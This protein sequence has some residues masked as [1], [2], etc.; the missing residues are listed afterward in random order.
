M[1]ANRWRMSAFLPRAAPLDVGGLGTDTRESFLHGLGDELRSAALEGRGHIYRS[2]LAAGAQSG[3][4]LPKRAGRLLHA[5]GA[6]LK[7]FDSIL[8]APERRSPE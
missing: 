3:I 2:Q 1:F 5:S 8:V 4:L 7:K 6:R